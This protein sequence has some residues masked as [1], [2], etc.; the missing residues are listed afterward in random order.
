MRPIRFVH[1]SDLHLDATFGGV[2]AAEEKVADA[3]ALSTLEALDRVV[4]LCIDREADFL[5]VAGDLH[6][7]AQCRS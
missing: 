1:T 4:Q 2:D 7:S 5:V 3:L 6:N